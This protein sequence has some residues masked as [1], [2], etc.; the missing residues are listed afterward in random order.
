MP[1]VGN[2]ALC[3]VLNIKYILFSIRNFEFM[4]NRYV[5]YNMQKNNIFH[6][7]KNNNKKKNNACARKKISKPKTNT[8][9][10]KGNKC[11]DVN[12]NVHSKLS[13]STIGKVPTKYALLFKHV[14]NNII[15][16]ILT[17]FTKD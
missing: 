13:E 3:F 12:K 15:L 4:K 7:S 10:A 9:K 5:G 1:V 14:F 8:K 6:I 11:Y 2:Q 16:I 17:E